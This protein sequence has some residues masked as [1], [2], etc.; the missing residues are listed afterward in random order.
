MKKTLIVLMMVLLSLVL[1]VSCENNS[2]T[3]GS[4]S[5]SG[6]SEALPTDI[7]VGDEVK[8]GSVTWK[9]LAVDEENNRALLISKDIL[10][11][12]KIN[13]ASYTDS[14]IYNTLRSEEFLNKYGLKTSYMKKVVFTDIGEKEIAKISDSGVDY[15]FL[16]SGTE[17]YGSESYFTDNESR[18]ATY[19]GEA[20]SWWLRTSDATSSDPAYCFVRPDGD[21]WQTGHINE[22]NFGVRPAFWYAWAETDY[23]ITYTI[24]DGANAAEG[25][26]SSYTRFEDTTKNEAV[27]ISKAPTKD[28]YTFKGWKL[29]GADDATVEATYTISA[30]TTGDIE[31]VAVWKKILTQGDAISNVGDTIL[32]GKKDGKDISWKALSVDTEQKQ[33]LLISEDILEEKPLNNANVSSYKDTA[34]HSYLNNL[35]DGGFFKSY[36]ISTDYVSVKELSLNGVTSNVYALLLSAEEVT[37][38]FSTDNDRIAKYNGSAKA[39]WLRT[40]DTATYNYYF[41]YV[42]SDSVINNEYYSRDFG[43]RPAFWYKWN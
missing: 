31:L 41:D 3:P 20:S 39:W 25:N 40:S 38:Y 17:A 36:G 15:L 6:G 34:I 35:E 37:N 19:N 13:T 33:A 11:N 8:I 27:T 21:V 42:G 14:D 5:S 18:I 32:I 23:K 4:D 1:V 24:G 22:D 29:T 7:K 16:L 9:A 30:E 43:I 28:G 2:N 10:E 26:P 12:V